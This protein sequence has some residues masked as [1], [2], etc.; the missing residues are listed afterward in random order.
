MS[1]GKG[2]GMKGEERIGLVEPD[3]WKREFELF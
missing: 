3:Q 2:V 1:I